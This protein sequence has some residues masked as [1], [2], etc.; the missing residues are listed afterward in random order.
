MKILLGRGVEDSSRLR[1]RARPGRLAI[2]AIFIF[3]VLLRAACREVRPA[4]ATERVGRKFSIDRRRCFEVRAL[5]QHCGDGAPAMPTSKSSTTAETVT[6]D[7]VVCATTMIS[8]S[9]SL[10]LSL[11]LPRFFSFSLSLFANTGSHLPRPEATRVYDILLSAV[12]LFLGLLP[13]AAMR[14]D[15]GRESS[16]QGNRCCFYTRGCRTVFSFFL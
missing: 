11:S 8:F 5:R 6:D 2:S 12:F 9:L 14:R 16:L 4:S 7:D 3:S 10:S 1:A 13:G 15:P